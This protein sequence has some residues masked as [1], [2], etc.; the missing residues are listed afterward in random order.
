MAISDLS[1]EEKIKLADLHKELEEVVKSRSS[2]DN[3]IYPLFEQYDKLTE[4]EKMLDS[5]YDELTSNDIGGLGLAEESSTRLS[6]IVSRIEEIAKEKKNLEDQI[7]EANKQYDDIKEKEINLESEIKSV[8][9][10]SKENKSYS[11]FSN[12]PDDMVYL[13]KKGNVI[14]NNVII[15]KDHL[16]DNVDTSDV[17]V[18]FKKSAIINTSKNVT[19]Y[20][21]SVYNS[22]KNIKIEIPN[23][24]EKVSSVIKKTIDTAKQAYK[25]GYESEEKLVDQIIDRYK[26]AQEKQKQIENEADNL[27]LV[28][29]ESINSKMYL[30]NNE[31][32]IETPRVVDDSKIKEEKKDDLEVEEKNSA[33]I[34]LN[35]EPVKEEIKDIST[36]NLDNNVEI[37][38]NEQPKDEVSISLEDKNEKSENSLD[39]SKDKMEN[40]VKPYND[41]DQ[42]VTPSKNKIAKSKSAKIWGIQELFKAYGAKKAKGKLNEFIKSEKKDIIESK[43]N[44]I[45]ELQKQKRLLEQYNNSMDNVINIFDQPESQGLVA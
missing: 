20:I 44:S 40:T 21:K 18:N 29:D 38:K 33:D 17:V 28:G 1:I 3:V 32:N 27:K 24:A 15:K 25:E 9:S 13:D 4:E 10:I 16:L 2:I 6:D 7:L 8:K 45:N 22:S 26:K 34:N 30:D 42:V 43:K 41:V 36:L 12:N 39:I 19:N 14:G 37:E 5:D 31:I 35:N 11:V 23:L